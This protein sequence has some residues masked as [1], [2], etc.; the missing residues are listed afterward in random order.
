MKGQRE[1]VLTKEFDEQGA[2]LSGGEFQKLVCARVF[3]DETK[4]SLFDEP[5]SALDPISESELFNSIIGSVRER[6]G[7]FIS[8]RLSSVKEADR[9]FMLEHGRVI[10]QG[11]HRE[12]MKLGGAYSE[13]YKIQ[14]RNYFTFDRETVEAGV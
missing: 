3:L 7:I 5:S 8:H 11:T 2:L 13:M 14:E 10:E 1:T 4:V 9:V 12:L 6:T